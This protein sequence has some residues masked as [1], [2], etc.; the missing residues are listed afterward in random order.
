MALTFEGNLLINILCWQALIQTSTSTQL[1]QAVSHSTIHGVT[2]VLW[3]PPLLKLR[4]ASSQRRYSIF[5]L[6]HIYVIVSH[7]NCLISSFYL[8]FLFMSGAVFL[9][10]Q[11]KVVKLSILFILLRNQ[12]LVGFWTN[13]YKKCCIIR[14]TDV[15]YF[16][17]YFHENSEIP[18][19]DECWEF[20][21]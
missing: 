18:I 2:C 1:D 17:I 21:C 12:I 9:F 16:Q 4:L 6:W 20:V 10:P 14:K 8:L 11:D 13:G 15:I 5:C 7:G 3:Q 19:L